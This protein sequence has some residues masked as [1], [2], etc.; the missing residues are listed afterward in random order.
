MNIMGKSNI[1][2]VQSLEVFRLSGKERELKARYSTDL[3]W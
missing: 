1:R 2:Q 3:V